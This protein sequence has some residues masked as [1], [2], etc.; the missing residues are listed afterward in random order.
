MGQPASASSF[1]YVESGTSRLFP[2]CS[3]EVEY[4]RAPRYMELFFSLVEEIGQFVKPWEEDHGYPDEVGDKFYTRQIARIS[5]ETV[6]V[7]SEK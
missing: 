1:H 7:K 2:S 6:F 4:V 5:K 3:A